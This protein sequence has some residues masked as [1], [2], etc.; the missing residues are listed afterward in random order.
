MSRWYQTHFNFLLIAFRF[1]PPHEL[2]TIWVF[3][4]TSP[5]GSHFK[6]L[7]NAKLIRKLLPATNNHNWYP[8]HFDITNPFFVNIT[9]SNINR[10]WKKSISTNIHFAIGQNKKRTLRGRTIETSPLINSTK[11]KRTLI[12]STST[13][14]PTKSQKSK[15]NH[16]QTIKQ[17]LKP[18]RTE[19][20]C[21][22]AEMDPMSCGPP[23]H[24][25]QAP[26]ILTEEPLKPERIEERFVK[27]DS[28][29]SSPI[30]C[31]NITKSVREGLDPIHCNALAS[32]AKVF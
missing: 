8:G 28:D 29:V 1:A 31:S 11:R 22:S 15:P 13:S 16:V 7:P 2:E 17:P 5:I 25:Q 4:I 3:P 19:D 24:E 30:C 12:H 21:N 9:F 27:N 20:Y 23:A 26:E 10:I 6:L 32:F 18:T 14:R